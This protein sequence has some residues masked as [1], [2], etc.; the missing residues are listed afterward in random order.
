MPYRVKPSKRRA[1]WLNIKMRTDGKINRTDAINLLIESIERGDYAYPKDWYVQ[2][3]WRNRENVHNR[4]GEF[5]SEMHLSKRS[6]DGFDKAVL[7]Y[8]RGKL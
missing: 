4:I 7:N 1:L 5:T 2:I 3:E 8:L 6:S